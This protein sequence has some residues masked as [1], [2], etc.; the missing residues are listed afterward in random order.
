MK[1]VEVPRKSRVLRKAQFGCL[2]GVHTINITKGCEFNC[3]YCYARGYPEVPSPGLVYL[4]SNT[5]QKLA[6]E[7]DNPRR[8]SVI[9][10][11]VFNTASDC[12]QHSPEVLD[13]TYNTMEVLL[14]RG[15]GLSFLSK[16]CIPDRFI[17]LFSYSPD[18]VAPKIGIVSVN[19]RYQVLFEPQAPTAGERLENIENLKRAGMDVEVRIDPII[20]FITDDELSIR[21]L[22]RS[23]ARRGVSRVSINYLHLRPLVSDQIRQELPRKEFALLCSCFDTQG[24][25]KVGTSTRSKLVPLTLR[26]KGYTRFV[27]LSK[28]YGIRCLICSCKN[29][30]MY[31]QRCRVGPKLIRN[32]K[33][34]SSSE[35]GQLSLFDGMYPPTG[36]GGQL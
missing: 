23:L 21:N 7:L 26:R 27:E 8:R 25:S 32:T 17:R 2:R 9:H 13:V 15:I 16:G 29:P 18:L 4:Y 34:T 6:R 24:W 19:Q 36:T 22:Y 35:A 5:A 10:W 3:V 33:N 31:A 28:D 1:V 20:P 12:F 11:V 14:E 30:D